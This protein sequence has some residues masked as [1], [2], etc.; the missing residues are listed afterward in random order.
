MPEQSGKP[1]HTLKIYKDCQRDKMTTTFNIYKNSINLPSSPI[2]N[3][4]K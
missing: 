4:Q 2:I 3:Y 1:L